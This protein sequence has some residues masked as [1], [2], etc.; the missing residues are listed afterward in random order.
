MAR[1]ALIS[2]ATA[3]S[4][5]AAHALAVSRSTVGDRCPVN[6]EL[7]KN[8]AELGYARFLVRGSSM[9]KY[10][11][12]PGNVLATLAVFGIDS[13]SEIVPSARSAICPRAPATNR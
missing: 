6:V 12:I 1:A 7:T 13:V 11:D 9:M 8:A 4:T 5:R 10:T 2:S 3:I